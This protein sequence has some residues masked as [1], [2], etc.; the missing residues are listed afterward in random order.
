MERGIG[1]DEAD[2]SLDDEAQEEGKAGDVEVALGPEESHVHL[3]L[4]IEM[5]VTGVRGAGVV[6][7]TVL[8]HLADGIKEEED[9]DSDENVEVVDQ[10][11]LQTL[12]EA[13][14]EHLVPHSGRDEWDEQE[15]Y[16]DNF[17]IETPRYKSP[18]E[19]HLGIS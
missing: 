10:L 12:Q 2:K 1:G 17:S 15:H 11:V 8:A 13:G 5:L 7:V 4:D 18:V 3:H 16:D 9:Q 19:T 6:L 14:P